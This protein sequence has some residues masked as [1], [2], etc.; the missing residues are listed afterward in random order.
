MYWARAYMLVHHA[1]CTARVCSEG[2]R[3]ERGCQPLISLNNHQ[4]IRSS[5]HQVIRSSGHQVISHQTS[6]LSIASGRRPQHTEY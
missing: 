4:V 2:P 3:H 6:F 5:G 1:P